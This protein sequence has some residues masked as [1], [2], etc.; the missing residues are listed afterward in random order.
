ME[1]SRFDDVLSSLLH[2]NMVSQAELSCTSFWKARFVGA[3]VIPNI[4]HANSSSFESNYSRS[5][6]PCNKL[7]VLDQGPSHNRRA[8]RTSAVISESWWHLVGIDHE[9]VCR[10]NIGSTSAQ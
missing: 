10:R 3:K 1:P 7:S 8:S 2:G 9:Q 5:F 6:C 4:D